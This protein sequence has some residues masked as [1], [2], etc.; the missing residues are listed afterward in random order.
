MS[1]YKELLEQQAKLTKQIE[2]ARAIE[3]G[4]A[5]KVCR[6]LI[7]QWGL[8][9]QDVGFV[10]TQ[11]IPTKR[12]P[13]GD[14]TFAAKHQTRKPAPPLYRDPKTGATW[15]G[16]G[17]EPGWLKDHRDEYLIRDN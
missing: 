12:V 15:S 17:K 5:A 3:A 11:H 2:E 7:E 8:S 1:R 13:K 6:Q 9:P 14:K 4:E 16:R 10:R